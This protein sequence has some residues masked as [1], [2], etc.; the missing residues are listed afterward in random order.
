MRTTV[1]SW[2]R[3]EVH[4]CNALAFDRHGQLLL[5]RHSYQNPQHWMLPGGGLRRR[6]DPV[7]AAAREL[8]EETG[9]RLHKAHWFATDVMTIRGGWRNRVE[10]VA[11]ITDDEPHAEHRELEDARFFPLDAL[12]SLTGGSVLQR[13]ALWRE[14][15]TSPD[16][17][18]PAPA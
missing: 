12:P 1:W 7:T 6:E 14:W 5:V 18:P 11:G 15:R 4:G 16:A 10:L 3:A 8:F 13:I 9:C 17:P 2:T